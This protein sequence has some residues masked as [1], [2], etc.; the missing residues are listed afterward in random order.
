MKKEEIIGS[1]NALREE[2]ITTLDLYRTTMGESYPHYVPQN[3]MY[4]SDMRRSKDEL[5][6]ELRRRQNA[7]TDMKEMMRK[8]LA[9]RDMLS[10][11]EGR[12]FIKELEEKKEAMHN[13]INIAAKELAGSF[14]KVLAKA[15]LSDWK[16]SA[17]DGLFPVYDHI[18]FNIEMKNNRRA[19][20]SISINRKNG[21]WKM[22]VSS[23]LHCG[24]N[25]TIQDR[26]EQY[27]QFKAYITICD[28]CGIFQNW[29]ET[30]YAD[31][32]KV[33]TKF[34]DDQDVLEEMIKNPAEYY[35]K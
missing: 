28:A 26:T 6:S 35:N 16:V 12:K 5:E 13:N 27:Q 3:C 8:E 29:M 10:T 32:C 11:E 30:T 4:N 1:Y 15:G 17:T 7:I 20:L 19:S 22:D 14:E 33:F 2:V 25:K 9:K 18:Y 23:S 31:S 34:L 24:A 21:E